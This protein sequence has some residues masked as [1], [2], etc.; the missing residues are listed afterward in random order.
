MRGIPTSVGCWWRQRRDTAGAR[1]GY[2]SKALRAR[3]SGSSTE[4]IAYADRASERLRRRYYNLI[5]SGKAA[6][7]AKTAVARE[8]ACFIW[9]M[10]TDHT[11]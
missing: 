5:F 9:G 3:Q 4:T 11:A 7:V 2:K 8:L 1:V 6:N 10:M